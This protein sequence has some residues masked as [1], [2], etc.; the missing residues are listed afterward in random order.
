MTKFEKITK[1]TETLAEFL[2]LTQN[3]ECVCC[4]VQKECD[5]LEPTGETNNLCTRSWEAWLNREEGII[6]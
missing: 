1:D 2:A 4:M 5:A 3:C 6:K